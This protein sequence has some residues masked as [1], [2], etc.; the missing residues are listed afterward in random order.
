LHIDAVSARGEV[1]KVVE[2]LPAQR[3]LSLGVI[4]G[5]NIWKTDLSA[6]LDW[7]EPVHA[8]LKERLWIAPS[9]SLLHVPVDLASEEELDG[10]IRSWLAFALQKLEELR[11]VAGALNHG[12]DSVTEALARNQDAIRSRRA[13]TRVHNAAVQAAVEKIDAELGH[14]KSPYS[15][16]A[17]KQSSLLGLPAYP[18]TTIG[19]FPQT[20]E[21]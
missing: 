1:A 10:E 9:C 16:R 17:E 18:T 5:R 12:R 15:E 6:T 20:P 3:V 2:S 19:S 21:I 7:L 14:R 13:S 11:I 4:S 8:L